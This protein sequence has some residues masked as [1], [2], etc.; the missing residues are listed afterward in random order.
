MDKKLSTGSCQ[1]D[2]VTEF[3]VCVFVYYTWSGSL[4]TLSSV[5][6]LVNWFHS[7]CLPVVSPTPI[8]AD[9][10]VLPFIGSPCISCL[11]S[12]SLVA[13]V[14]HF[15][16]GC[17][18]SVCFPGRTWWCI[19]CLGLA[20]VS[21]GPLARTIK[22]G[23]TIIHLIPGVSFS[24]L[25]SYPQLHFMTVGHSQ[26]DQAEGEELITLW[27]YLQRATESCA[28]QAEVHEEQ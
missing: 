17:I 14:P 27:E 4:F 10:L 16:L 12:S 22:L 28:H 5:S 9:Y 25:W 8:F 24:A 1:T 23:L 3:C 13:F 20:L 11:Y 2:P 26:M 21:T 18:C 6:C 19:L 15:V 7:L